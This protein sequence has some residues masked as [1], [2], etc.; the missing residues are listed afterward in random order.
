MDKQRPKTLETN[1]NLWSTP[2]NDPGALRLSCIVILAKQLCCDI[3]CFGHFFSGM[4]VLF[5]V[6]LIGFVNTLSSQHVVI[7]TCRNSKDFH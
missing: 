6:L 4:F 2:G 1:E 5:S 7:V 3:F